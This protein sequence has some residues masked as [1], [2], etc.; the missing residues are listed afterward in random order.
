[1]FNS[2]LRLRFLVPAGG[3][4]LAG[5][6]LVLT[7]E[8]GA[9]K[10]K[11]DDGKIVAVVNGE[12]IERE[13]LVEVLLKRHGG[14]ELQQL[15][16][17]ALISQQKKRHGVTVTRKEVEEALERA[18]DQ[19]INAQKTRIT[20]QGMRWEDYLRYQGKTEEEVRKSIREK[21]RQ[22]DEAEDIMG[23]NVLLSKLTW[24]DFLTRDRVD[25]QQIR[26]ETEAEAKAIIKLVNDGKDFSEIVEQRV[27]NPRERVM[28]EIALGDYRIRMDIPGPEFE[29]VALSLK[30]G[31]VSPPVKSSRG[32]HVIKVLKHVNGKRGTFAELERD[33]KKHLDDVRTGNLTELY[34][35]RLLI[36]GKINNESGL[37]VPVLEMLEER[38]KQLKGEGEDGTGE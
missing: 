22:R 37:R 35:W 27:R 21:Y 16:I 23:K 19:E 3:M 10:P 15:I 34:V 24:Y 30:A 1:M 8:D 7:A 6:M 18:V 20:R 31:E 33:V 13:Q 38:E 12:N 4:V 28:E 2:M 36:D 32:W 5:G 11:P 29:R 9:E 25:V 17:E 26:V 14:A